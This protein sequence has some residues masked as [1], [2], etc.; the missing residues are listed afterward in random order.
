MR[1][2]S[3]KPKKDEAAPENEAAAS[4]DAS[5]GASASASPA[6]KSGGK[7]GRCGGSRKQVEELEKRVAE[8]EQQA[9]EFQEESKR[10]EDQW[11][12]ARAEM[13]N[14]R[15]RAAREYQEERRRAAERIP[16]RE[17]GPLVIASTLLVPGY[18]DAE[19]VGRIASFIS[20][21]GRDI[22]YSLLA[23]GPGY[24]MGDM[25]RT[26]RQHVEE[27]RRAALDAGLTNVHIGNLHFTV[28][29]CFLAAARNLPIS[30]VASLP[31]SSLAI[32]AYTTLPSSSRPTSL[33]P[34][35]GT[36]RLSALTR[37]STTSKSSPARTNRSLT[38]RPTLARYASAIY[39]GTK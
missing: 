1:E 22:P 24:L 5:A 36:S 2:S 17:D 39:S 13:E 29:R 35:A 33:D 27:A 14:V 16:E 30:S 28:G 32:R 38:G 19:E 7:R 15:R 3:T 20:R 18:V 23:F 12:R 34:L 10:F 11:L 9:A 26:S 8:L 37:G 21:H 4:R 25:P 6:K 31:K